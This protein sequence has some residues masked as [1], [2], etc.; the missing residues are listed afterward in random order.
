MW[1]FHSVPR[2]IPHWEHPLPPSG[3][4]CF[5]RAQFLAWG[6]SCFSQ[7]NIQHSLSQTIH[8]L[9]LNCL[10][11]TANFVQQYHLS[12]FWPHVQ[13]LNPISQNIF[14]L[15]KFINILHIFIYVSQNYCYIS[16]TVKNFHGFAQHYPK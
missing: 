6:T 7:W 14:M 8:S 2:F 12:M 15:N 16:I 5:C 3:H 1:Y 13:N 4:D 9:S 10:S 11:G